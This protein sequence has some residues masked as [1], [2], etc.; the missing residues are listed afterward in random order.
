MGDTSAAENKKKKL[1]V[2][3]NDKDH[4]NFFLL[5]ALL[6]DKFYETIKNIEYLGT[7]FPNINNKNE[8]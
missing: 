5:L 3:S 2:K 1:Q 7:K 8:E 6:P 4:L